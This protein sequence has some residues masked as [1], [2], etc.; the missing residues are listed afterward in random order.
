MKPIELKFDAA[1]LS[2]INDGLMLIPYGRAAP[3]VA[4]INAQ[5][6]ASF[7]AKADDRVTGGRIDA[8]ADKHG[9]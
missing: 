4:S 8:P 5:I 7:N 1:Q 2:V 3:V 9:D 6:Q